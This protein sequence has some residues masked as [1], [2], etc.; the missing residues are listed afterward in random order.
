MITV[1]LQSGNVS[2]LTKYLYSD[3]LDELMEHA[4]I[5]E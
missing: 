3:S 5:L 2:F 1:S 4:Y